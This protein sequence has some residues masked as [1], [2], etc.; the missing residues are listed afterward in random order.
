M[1]VWGLGL[2]LAFVPFL[3]VRFPSMLGVD[4]A[5][6]MAALAQG[7]TDPL[8]VA[9]LGLSVV[10]L[11]LGPLALMAL[12]KLNLLDGYRVSPPGSRGRILWLVAGSVLAFW[13]ILAPLGGALLREWTGLEIFM[14]PL[15]AGAV[16]APLVLVLSM[17]M[18][19][20]YAGALD[21]ALAVQRSTIYGAAGALGLVTFAGLENVL[22]EYVAARLG[23]PGA[24]GSMAAGAAA[25]AVMLPFQ[26]GIKRV[27]ARW[28][29]TAGADAPAPPSSD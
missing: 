29:Q 23:L 26:A 5:G 13:M 7:R 4:M 8:L 12:G 19:V 25:A 11:A 15:L 20:L 17:G 21:P 2:G 3:L 28:L 1:T 9:V 14:G 24:V 27:A 18:A 16:L 10:I 6:R 22:S